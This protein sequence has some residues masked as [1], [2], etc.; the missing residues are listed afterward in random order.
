MQYMP[1][2][3]QR[4]PKTSK[5][6]FYVLGVVVF[7]IIVA[8]IVG[9]TTNW[10]GLAA[11]SSDEG[12]S[13]TKTVADVTEPGESNKDAKKSKAAA[14]SSSSSSA[15]TNGENQQQF[16]A[17]IKRLDMQISNLESVETLNRKLASEFSASKTLDDKVKQVMVKAHTDIAENVKKQAALLDSKRADILEGKFSSDQLSL[18]FKKA[19]KIAVDLIDPQIERLKRGIANV[20]MAEEFHKEQAKSL[21]KS[22]PEASKTNALLAAERLTQRVSYEFRLKLLEQEKAKLLAAK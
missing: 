8:L 16:E 20:T 21:E 1:G 11:P 13:S 5:A 10:F 2:I 12:G 9:A 3:V 15:Q 18:E 6:I 19:V 14:S 7:L 22:A 17:I 4:N